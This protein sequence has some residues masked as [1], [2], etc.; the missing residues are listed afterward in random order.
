MDEQLHDFFDR[1]Q[2]EKLLDNTIV[3]ITS[4]HG[5]SFGE[6][7]LITHNFH[8]RGDYESTHHVPLIIVLPQAT[9]GRKINAQVSIAQIAPTIYNFVR[10][11]WT[12]FRQKHANYAS[13]LFAASQ[14]ALTSVSLPDPRLHPIATA[15]MLP[16]LPHP[17]AAWRLGES[18]FAQRAAKMKAMNEI[19]FLIEEAPEGGYTAHA[20]GESIFTESRRPPDAR[21]ECARCGRVPFRCS[22]SAPD[23]PASLH[24]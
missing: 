21:E 9:T 17:P 7:D 2:E 11:D 10:I 23:R 13:S 6:A 22:R 15:E 24:A 16:S 12:P 5:E 14:P 3:I 8:D 1:L 19:I 18:R 4:D 20:L